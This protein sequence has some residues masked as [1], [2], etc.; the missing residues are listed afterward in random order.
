MS[1]LIERLTG[2]KS[3]RQSKEINN[4]EQCLREQSI[5]IEKWLTKKFRE[6]F[7]EMQHAFK[8]LEVGGMVSRE[9]FIKVLQEYG[10]F[11][12]DDRLDTFL[13]RY[14]SFNFKLGW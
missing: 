10:L 14:N 5:N 2:K 12:K 11:L 4:D 9:D 1:Q 13:E 7:H 6:G 3:S 8:E